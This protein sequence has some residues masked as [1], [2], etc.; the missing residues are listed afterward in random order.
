MA[1]IAPDQFQ[2]HLG[3]QG[4]ELFVP[5]ERHPIL[6]ADPN[7]RFD[8]GKEWLHIHGRLSQGVS[9]AQANAAVA[10]I[11]SQLAKAYPA[12]NKLKAGG[13][14]AF[15]PLGVLDRSQFLRLRAVAMTL[16]G[17]VLLVVCL[18]ISGMMQV[19]GA[20]R[21]RELSIRQAIGASRL[22][23]A[24]HLLAEAVLLAA[25]GGTLAS[26]VLFNASRVISRLSGQP[27]PP[28]VRD[29]LQADL[30]MM[31]ICVGLCFLTSLVFGLLPA[32]RFSRP[33]I[34]SSLKDDAGVGG[35][36]VGR[37][38]RFT[39]ALQVAIAVPLLV[40]GGISLDRVRST[41]VADLGFDSGL[42]YAAPLELDAGPEQP[43][44][45]SRRPLKAWIIESEASGAILATPPA[46]HPPR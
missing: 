32:I 37:V 33:A 10:G 8:R 4:R 27:I 23:L 25:A 1:G 14:V 42:L 38:Q 20:M 31:A 18:N 16:T 7:A 28:Q 45:Q 35:L 9:I 12:T 19:R 2:G 30:S 26:L 13:V 34:I 44:A 29:A 5:L 15:D 24:R 36:R 6:A 40:M 3:L 11:T 21:E 46:S 41:A 22:Q 17:A 39:A 43:T